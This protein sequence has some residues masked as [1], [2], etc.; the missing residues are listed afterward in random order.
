MVNNLENVKREDWEKMTKQQ[1]Q[2]I[3][4]KMMRRK[5]SDILVV[6]PLTPL[7]TRCAKLAADMI[8]YN[9]NHWN[10]FYALSMRYDSIIRE[11]NTY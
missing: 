9:K 10:N 11:W 4:I 7:G 5:L 6:V 3:R 2:R 1:R 8:R